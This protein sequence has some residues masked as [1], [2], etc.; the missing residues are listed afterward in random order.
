[1]DTTGAG[2]RQG[3]ARRTGR[4]RGESGSREAILAAARARFAASG[5]D[6]TTIRAIAADA[7]VDPALVHHFFGTKER[8]FTA[9]MHLLVD[10]ATVVPELL[11]PGPDGLGERLA[12]L[13]VGL[14]RDERRAAPM[15]AL[16][17][18]AAAHPEAATLF[19]EFYTRSVLE[20]VAA[21]L[22]ADRPRLRAALCASQVMG[23]AM[24]MAVVGLRPLTEAAAE[25]LV[26]AY[27]PALQHY[28]TGEF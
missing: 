17:R 21:R 1:M 14:L 2:G 25:T 28:L 13:F 22:D 5:Y 23:L 9:C 10:P 15:L 11:R 3:G 27:A 24:A 8:L 12:R 20:R 19:R 26:A 18:S 16:L 6:G 7:G 4:R